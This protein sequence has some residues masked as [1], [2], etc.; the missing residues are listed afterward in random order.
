M[1]RLVCCRC[2]RWRS[3]ILSPLTLLSL[4]VEWWHF[5]PSQRAVRAGRTYRQWLRSPLK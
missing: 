2:F 5:G 1:S 3:V 4:A